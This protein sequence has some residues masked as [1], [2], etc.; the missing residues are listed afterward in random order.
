MLVFFNINNLNFNTGC[1]LLDLFHPLMQISDT[2]INDQVV[3]SLF[4]HFAV[5]KRVWNFL[6]LG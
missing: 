2:F 4:V 3:K 1:F 6:S 5:S